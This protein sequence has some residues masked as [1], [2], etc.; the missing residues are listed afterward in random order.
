[1]RKIGVLLWRKPE[2]VVAR[3]THMLCYLVG[4]TVLPII[5]MELIIHRSREWQW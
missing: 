3:P 4:G 1:V 5:S 2:A